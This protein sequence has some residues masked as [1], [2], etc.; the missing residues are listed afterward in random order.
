MATLDNGDWNQYGKYCGT[1]SNP[2]AKSAPLANMNF[3]KKN[4][5]MIRMSLRMFC[6]SNWKKGNMECVHFLN[7]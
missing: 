5:P 3:S 4:S 2:M 6:N 7:E 1:T